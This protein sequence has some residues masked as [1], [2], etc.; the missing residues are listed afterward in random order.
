MPRYGRPAPAV[1]ISA[2][3]RPKQRAYS[4]HSSFKISAGFDP[5]QVPEMT[6][7]DIDWVHRDADRK[8]DMAASKD[9]AYQM[10]EG[11]N[12]AYEPALA[13]RHSEGNAID[14]D[15]SWSSSTIQITDGAGKAVTI[16]STP[17]SGRNIDL[18]KVGKS[19]G[20]IKLVSDPPHWSSDGH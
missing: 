14:M 20:V 3:L 2:T 16:S 7:V 11:Y 19:Y 18:H 13:S 5:E 9:A 1:S 12:I 17:K 4:M 8:K 6:A 15:I 10:I